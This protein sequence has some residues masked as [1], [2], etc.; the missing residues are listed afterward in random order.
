MGGACQADVRL[1]KASRLHLQETAQVQ[2]LAAEAAASLNMAAPDLISIVD[3]SLPTA[4]G[5]AGADFCS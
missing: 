3:K 1:I 4:C 2:Q 5:L